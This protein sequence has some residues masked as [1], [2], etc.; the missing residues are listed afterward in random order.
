MG[1]T[2]FDQ[3]ETQIAMDSWQFIVSVFSNTCLPVFGFLLVKLE[4]MLVQDVALKT[5]MKWFLQKAR[6]VAR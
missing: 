3:F 6:I 2:I 1:K 5:T 4:K